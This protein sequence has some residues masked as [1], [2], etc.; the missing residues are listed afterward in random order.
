M[1]VLI[2]EDD[3]QLGPILVNGLASGAVDGDLVGTGVEAIQR[4]TDGGYAVIVLD[5]ALPDVS[6]FDVCRS[7]REAGVD[8]PVLLLSACASVDDR[9]QGLDAGGDD[10][11]TKPFALRELV[12][13]V[14]ALSRRGVN[15]RGVVLRV[16]DLRLDSVRRQVHRGNAAIDLT[17]KEYV[18]LEALMR[19]PGCVLSRSD[20]LQQGWGSCYESRSNVVETMIRGLRKKIDEP[21]DRHSVQTVRGAGWR[22][23]ADDG[24]RTSAGRLAE[25]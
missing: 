12:A 19:E 20:L 25:K 6:G 21:F 16:G 23:G 2:V 8:T 18:F 1:R 24:R 15:P 11:L 5:V 4:S 3:R 7:M 9:V 22:I 17:R 13:R 14:R 10:Y